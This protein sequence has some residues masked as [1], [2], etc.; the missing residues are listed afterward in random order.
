MKDYEIETDIG[1]GGELEVTVY[2]ALHLW[3]V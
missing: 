3:A 2:Y 1:G